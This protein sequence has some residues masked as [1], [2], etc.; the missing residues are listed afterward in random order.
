[1][2]TMCLRWRNGTTAQWHNGIKAQR[3]NGENSIDQYV[4][5]IKIVNYF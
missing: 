1:M 2:H 4:Q 3:T 5:G